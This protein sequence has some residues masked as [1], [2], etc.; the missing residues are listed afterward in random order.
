MITDY[1]D[2]LHLYGDL[3]EYADMVLAFIEKQKKENLPAGRY[4]LENGVF[5]SVQSYTTRPLEGSQMESHKKYCDLQYIVSGNEKIYWPSLRKLTVVDDHTEDGDYLL[6][7][8]G[9]DQGYTL[10]KRGMFGFY[11]PE[12]GHMPSIAV[13]DP[14]PVTK[15][16]FKI[17]VKM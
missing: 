13:T 1:A 5:A 8:S 16:V 6:Y 14:E 15:I 4:D 12:D 17:P 11:A 2:K 9:V 10:M 3:Q 7:E